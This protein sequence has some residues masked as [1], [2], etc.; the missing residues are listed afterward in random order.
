MFA[1]Q[2]V[3]YLEDYSVLVLEDFGHAYLVVHSFFKESLIIEGLGQLYNSFEP[4]LYFR[5]FSL[6][7][8]KTVRLRQLIDSIVQYKNSN[9]ILNWLN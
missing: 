9:K 6:L 1:I 4:F 3:K 7:V 8:L 2:I 5:K